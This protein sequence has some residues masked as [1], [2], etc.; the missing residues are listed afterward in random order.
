MCRRCDQKDELVVESCPVMISCHEWVTSEGSYS[1]LTKSSRSY[2]LVP[3]PLFLH[4]CSYTLVPTPLFLHPC[5]YTLVSVFL[6]EE[7]ED[8]LLPRFLFEVSLNSCFLAP[9]HGP[10]E[11]PDV[12][13]TL[14]TNSFVKN[15]TNSRIVKMDAPIHK[16]TFPPKSAIN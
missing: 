10:R 9:R 14:Y 16:P 4:P 3:T 12:P 7:A 11:P 8:V 6:G 2:T 13:C 15:S 5:S 1:H